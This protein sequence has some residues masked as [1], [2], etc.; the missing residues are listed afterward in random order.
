MVWGVGSAAGL[1]YS[2]H[3]CSTRRIAS[4]RID[5][6]VDRPTFPRIHSVDTTDR[7]GDQTGNDRS[8]NSSRLECLYP[9]TALAVAVWGS[10]MWMSEW[11]D[12][13]GRS[14][15]IAGRGRSDLVMTR[16]RVF[17]CV[18]VGPTTDCTRPH[19][20]KS[21]NNFF[22]S[23]SASLLTLMLKSPVTMVVI[24]CQGFKYELSRIHT[25]QNQAWGLT[26]RIYLFISSTFNYAS[27]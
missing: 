2:V 15:T 3:A 16:S 25:F 22:A 19:D 26:I 7:I 14:T 21:P 4:Y 23:V 1:F 27:T 9:R 10:S 18:W 17:P 12:T 5:P 8:R 24:G 20:C 13:C 11:S 6:V